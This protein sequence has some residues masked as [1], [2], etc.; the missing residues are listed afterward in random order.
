MYPVSGTLESTT[1]VFPARELDDEVGPPPAVVA[2][3][4]LLR[5]EVAVVQH[6]GQLAAPSQLDLSPHAAG[7]RAPERAGEGGRLDTQPLARRRHMLHL[8]LQPGVG[9]RAFVLDLEQ[10]FAVL[11]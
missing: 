4:G 10:H 1:I 2:V 5:A 9:A 3:G 7:V 8:L 6:P 11:R